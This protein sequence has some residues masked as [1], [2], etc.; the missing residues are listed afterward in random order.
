MLFRFFPPP[1][2]FKFLRY[3]LLKMQN[4]KLNF[5]KPT[6]MHCTET[7]TLKG[8]IVEKNK[9]TGVNLDLSPKNLDTF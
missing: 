5:S 3:K 7:F 8:K 2:T 9:Q 6:Y 1:S 4:Q